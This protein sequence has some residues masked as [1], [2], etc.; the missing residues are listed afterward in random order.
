MAD[1]NYARLSPRPFN[2]AWQLNNAT[3]NYEFYDPVH[4]GFNSA[5]SELF[6]GAF[7]A[8]TCPSLYHPRHPAYQGS[9]TQQAGSGN[10]VTNQN[11]YEYPANGDPEGCFDIYGFG[12]STT[13]CN[14]PSPPP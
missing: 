11:C 2:H 10:I 5:L 12:G 1:H 6:A 4:N 3:E 13:L 8:L 7:L 9:I 14:P